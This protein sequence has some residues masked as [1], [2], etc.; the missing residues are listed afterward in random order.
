V[1][2]ARFEDARRGIEWWATPGGALKPGETYLDAARREIKEET[3]LELA[4]PGP[5]V[6]TRE[7]V[8]EFGDHVYRQKER[9]FLVHVAAFIPKLTGL[10]AA[11]A[12][13]LRDLRWWTPGELESTGDELSP[14]DLPRLLR[15]LLKHGPPKHPV[16]VGL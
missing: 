7:H 16:R 12:E 5:W 8:L 9:F 14:R 3:G 6:W 2:L 13:V 10:E 1:P 15:N 4:E 11:E